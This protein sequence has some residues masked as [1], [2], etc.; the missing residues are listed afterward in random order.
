MMLREA[1]DL[2]ET[3]HHWVKDQLQSS[4]LNLGSPRDQL[5]ASKNKYQCQGPTQDQFLWNRQG[6]G[7]GTYIFFQSFPDET[8]RIQVAPADGSS[9][10]IHPV[11]YELSPSVLKSSQRCHGD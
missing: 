1:S 3:H 4:S 2:P 11:P 7:S 5:G 10:A 9:Q 6:L 8:T